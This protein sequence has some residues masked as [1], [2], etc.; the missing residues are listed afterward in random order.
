[1]TKDPCLD[2]LN[3]L[4]QVLL[5]QL[6]HGNPRRVPSWK[7]NKYEFVLEYGWWYDPLPLPDGVEPGPPQEC[8]SNAFNLALEDDFMTYCEG[9]VLSNASSTLV[10]HAWV[11][12]G[13]GRAIDNTLR[14]PSAAYAGV[15]FRTSF[16]NLYHLQNRAVIC[17]LDDWEHDWPLLEELGDRPEEWLETKGQGVDCLPTE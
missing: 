3:H 9:F 14:E 11:T 13:S 4:Q 8:I 17:L 6:R 5:E 12:D 16:T 7:R 2:R 15:P 10:H 1:M